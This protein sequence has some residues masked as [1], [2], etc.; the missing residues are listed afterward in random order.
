MP[1][2]GITAPA[3][4]EDIGPA[5]EEAIIGQAAQ[6]GK[7]MNNNLAVKVHFFDMCI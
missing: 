2:M 5:V 1:G 4:A 6:E 3:G 7:S